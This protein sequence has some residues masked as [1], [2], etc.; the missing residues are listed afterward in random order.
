MALDDPAPSSF[1]KATADR[2]AVTLL[3]N[4]YLGRSVSVT[5]GNLCKNGSRTEGAAQRSRLGP[6]GDVAASSR[7][8][9][10]RR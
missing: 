3:G 1:A 7:T 2:S 5:L 6:T 8:L 4:P 9:R 10:C